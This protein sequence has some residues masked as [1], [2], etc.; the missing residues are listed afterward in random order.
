[1]DLILRKKHVSTSEPRRER[2]GFALLVTIVLV[3]FLVLIVLALAS[4]T[5]VETQVAAN[6]QVYAQARQNALMALNVAIG[7]LQRYAGP[8]NR[9][10]A[11]AN[12]MGEAV[13]NPWFTGVWD[14]DAAGQTEP[15]TW[16]VSGNEVSPRRFNETSAL[17]RTAADAE[18]PLVLNENGVATNGPETATPN[19]VLLVGANVAQSTGTGMD[20]GAVV[21][22]GVPL[23]AEVAGFAGERTVGR[24]AY[25]VG[26][27]GVKASLALADRSSEVT[28]A[29]W[30]DGTTGSG[31]DMRNRLRQQVG[32]SPSFFRNTAAEQFGF[33]PL[34]TVNR[35]VL[36]RL[37][38]PSQFTYLTP[39][40]SGVNIAEDFRTGFHAFTNTTYGVLANTLPASSAERGLMRDLSTNPELLGDAFEAYADYTVYMEEPGAD[41]KAIPPILNQDSM[42]RRYNITPKVVTE[43][44]P[45]RPRMEAGVAPVLNAFYIQF[46]ATHPSPTGNNVRLLSRAYVELWNPY[47]A[48]L[49]PPDDL[50]LEISGLPTN[51]LIADSIIG[52]AVSVNYSNFTGMVV[53]SP[54]DSSV[55]RVT[56][57][58][59]NTLGRG[60][61]ASWLPGR[62]YAWSTQP[63]TSPT[64]E[65]N[66]HI[67]DTPSGWE[68][69][70]ISVPRSGE[71]RNL[72]V[73]CPEQVTL[74]I[75]LKKGDDV[76][77]VYE[78]E[79]FSDFATTN[80]HTEGG[81]WCFAYAMRLK[82]PSALNRDRDWITNSDGDFRASN[83]DG[84]FF[85]PF[86]T[87]LDYDPEAYFNSL[88]TGETTSAHFLIYR[89]M[90]SPTGAA[91]ASSASANHDAPVF[92]LPR[93]PH[94]SLGELQ[95]LN[96]PELRPFALG[97]PWGGD[98][99]TWFD[100]YYFS[101]LVDGVE[102]DLASGQPLPAWYMKPV[103]TSQD[104]GAQMDAELI[105][106]GGDSLT[107]RRLLTEGAFNV[108]STSV[109][110]WRAV[111]SRARFDENSP[112]TRALIENAGAAT[113][114]YNGTQLASGTQSV[115]ERLLDSTLGSNVGGAAFFR[116]PQSAQETYFWSNASIEGQLSKQAFR[117]G[118]RGGTQ[119]I[120]GSTL[121]RLNSTQVEAIATRIVEGIRLH[122]AN[123]GPFRSMAEF[124][125]PQASLAGQ[126]VI[127]RAITLAAVNPAS[128]SANPVPNLTDVGFSSLT[129]T[130]ADV[131]TV[132][133]PFLRNRS[134]TFSVRVYGE[135]LNPATGEVGARVW[136]EALVQ[137][138]PETVNP[139]DNAATPSATGL[140][141]AFKIIGFRWLNLTDI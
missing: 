78:S 105:R 25:W 68:Y 71:N 19:R 132:L 42:R 67:K 64:A 66:F 22:P 121:Q 99:L 23:Q 8:D 91:L 139:D 63:G 15:L 26:D 136:G 36:K 112:F 72:T 3:A 131:M 69:P 123:N 134:D 137:R 108:N 5:R 85:I 38:T 29:P 114:P 84:R 80:K 32:G 4:F 128:I 79:A 61:R 75:T 125:G 90:G 24:Y 37:V 100:R 20:N 48:A 46:R 30:F 130:Q 117:Q 98:T 9:V 21:V 45:G 122:T 81:G 11:Q 76:L 127:Q 118:V 138:F 43:S 54:T 120:T 53:A 124:L 58:F 65:M 83:L 135:A 6:W 82:Q 104:G 89:G 109:D 41:N 27:K 14:A 141:R 12:L 129:L 140:G 101:G 35:D 111:L 18:V 56:L 94:L 96:F 51:V 17:D 97:N 102:P 126:S 55:F 39:A 7:Q 28:Y 92:E 59:T 57:P 119:A 60:D 44:E 86:N 110:A 73:V 1:M 93:L 13:E 77:A 88:G 49:V 10:T 107:S 103:A 95:H 133:A 16:L 116:F 115:D 62:M 106:D 113:N 31:H 52:E 40:N 70:S 34:L 2:R 47:T 87:N 50:S 74:T 33:D